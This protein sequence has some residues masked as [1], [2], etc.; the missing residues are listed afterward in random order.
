MLKSLAA[1]SNCSKGSSSS[2]Q[3]K[4]YRVHVISVP[5]VVCFWLDGLYDVEFSRASF[6][7]SILIILSP[8]LQEIPSAMSRV[9]FE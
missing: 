7:K 3:V 9:M 5:L 1:E 2:S 4:I 6:R 8:F